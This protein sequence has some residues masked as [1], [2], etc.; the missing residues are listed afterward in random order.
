MRQR[1]RG[2]VDTDASV[3]QRSLVAAPQVASAT[4]VPDAA[5]ARLLFGG[6]EEAR[7]AAEEQAMRLV[8]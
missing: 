7:S 1:G 6:D 5:V 2:F 3:K 8:D 4:P